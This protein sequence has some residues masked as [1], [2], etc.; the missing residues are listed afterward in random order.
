M[1]FIWLI[2]I[3]ASLIYGL[4]SGQVDLLNKVIL[5]IGKDTYEFVL[6][7][8]LA[9]SFWN[10]LMN[11]AN[12]AGILGALQ[13]LF[14]PLLK[15]MFPDIKDDKETLGYIA[16]NITINLFGLGS[17]ATPMG[18]KAM[19]GMQEHNLDKEVATRSMVT[20]LVL[21]TAGVTILS[22][23]IVSLRHSFGSL[24]PTAF[25]PFAIVSTFFASFVGILVDRWWNHG[26][27]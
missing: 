21:N 15:W 11:I 5:S 8:V 24:N 13:T 12:D 26:R 16:A 6:P 3:A 7:L 1:T 10:G 9:T 17:A 27:K 25:M 14:S 20:F 22:T 23:T 4:M 18:L 19:H 2:M